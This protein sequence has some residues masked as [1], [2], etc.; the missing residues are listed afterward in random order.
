DLEKPAVITSNFPDLLISHK[1]SGFPIGQ[2]IE[3]EQVC[4]TLHVASLNFNFFF[5]RPSFFNAALAGP[6]R[7]KSWCRYG[8][9][10]SHGRSRLRRWSGP[11]ATPGAR[12]ASEPRVWAARLHRSPAPAR[13]ECLSLCVR[14]V[15]TSPPKRCQCTG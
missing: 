14:A 7:A 13:S 3:Y 12:P 9:S 6:R 15:E 10:C 1:A 8:I 5:L 11:L 2:T 4:C